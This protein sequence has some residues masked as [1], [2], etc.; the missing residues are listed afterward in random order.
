MFPTGLT[1]RSGR[2]VAD[3]GGSGYLLLSS[4]L[5]KLVEGRRLVSRFVDESSNLIER[6]RVKRFAKRGLPFFKPTPVSVVEPTFLI[7]NCEVLSPFS[8]PTVK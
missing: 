8:K 3:L 2:N 6:E 4:S 1:A 7:P 5:M